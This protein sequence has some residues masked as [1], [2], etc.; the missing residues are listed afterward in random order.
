MPT[1]LNLRDIVLAD[2]V[3]AWPPA[4]GWWL[5]LGLLLLITGLGGWFYQRHQQAALKRAALAEF[6]RLQARF[7]QQSEWQPL[8]AELS[9]FLRRV[10][11]NLPAYQNRGCAGLHGEPW[12]QFLDEALD[13]KA[14]QQG[15]GRLLLQAPYAVQIDPKSDVHGLL[16]LVQR[17]LRVLPWTQKEPL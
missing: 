3:S 16:Q 8:L 7:D 4:L 12:L 15:A 1:E 17:W 2:S 10:C 9:I 11:L 14:F 6:E 5:L 13:G